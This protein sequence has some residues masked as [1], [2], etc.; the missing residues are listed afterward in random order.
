MH[1][2]PWTYTHTPAHIFEG[3]IGNRERIPHTLLK[4][5]VWQNILPIP[6]R[7]FSIVNFWY[8]HLTYRYCGIPYFYGIP[9]Y[10]TVDRST[11]I[12]K[13]ISFIHKIS[14]ETE[15]VYFLKLMTNQN[16]DELLGSIEGVANLKNWINEIKK[17]WN[18]G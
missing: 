8:R 17:E 10:V 6:Y 2:G 9:N 13:K 11:V 12:Q 18:H 16:G 4:T 1:R 15:G 7:S 14:L 5:A 3:W